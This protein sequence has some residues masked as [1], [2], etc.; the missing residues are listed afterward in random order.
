MF[1]SIRSNQNNNDNGSRLIYQQQQQ[2]Q[3]NSRIQINFRPVMGLKLFSH[4]VMISIIWISIMMMMVIIDA[5]PTENQ[6]KLSIKL[7]DHLQM[8][9]ESN[10]DDHHHHHRRRKRFISSDVGAMVSFQEILIFC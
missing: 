7:D 4:S 8:M 6:T 1:T 3:R 10:I 2:Q 5:A 9:I